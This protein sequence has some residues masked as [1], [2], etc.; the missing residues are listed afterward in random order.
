MDEIVMVQYRNLAKS[1]FKNAGLIDGPTMFIDSKA[2]GISICGQGGLDYMNVYIKAVDGII[3]D[4]KYL[5]SC[6]PPAN[7]V[8]EVLCDLVKGRTLEQAKALTKEEFFQVIG[9]DGGG[10]RRKVWGIIELL[11]RVIYRYE[12]RLTEARKAFVPH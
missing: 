11:N 5:C 12:M 1:G 3:T 7:V 4:I 9:S 10:V 6:D 8:V 2:E